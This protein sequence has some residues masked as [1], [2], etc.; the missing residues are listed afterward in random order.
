[1]IRTVKSSVDK[2]SL[3]NFCLLGSF[4]SPIIADER[5]YELFRKELFER[6]GMRKGSITQ[7]AEEAILLRVDSN[8]AKDKEKG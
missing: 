6:K 1:V 2:F 5:I 7:V 4:S 3:K 8:V